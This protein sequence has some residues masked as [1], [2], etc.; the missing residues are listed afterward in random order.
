MKLST[1]FDPSSSGLY[2][3]RKG[4]QS[5]PL[6]QDQL[7][8]WNQLKQSGELAIENLAGTDDI[9]KAES[10]LYVMRKQAKVESLKVVKEVYKDS[11]GNIRAFIL[12]TAPLTVAE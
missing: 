10:F 3:S 11:Q 2:R 5:K 1:H 12:V 8:N 4:K 9:K 7:N 6:T